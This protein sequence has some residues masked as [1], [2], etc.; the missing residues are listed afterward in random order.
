MIALF[1]VAALQVWA[2]DQSVHIAPDGTVTPNPRCREAARRYVQ[3]QE[4]RGGARNLG[5]LPPGVLMHA[6][7]KTVDGCAV[8]VLVQRGPDGRKLEIPAGA[9]GVRAAPA[10]APSKAQRLPKR[11]R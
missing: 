2:P 5:E 9:A 3:D 8:N 11:Q 7:L 4:M 10:H 6:V 1:V